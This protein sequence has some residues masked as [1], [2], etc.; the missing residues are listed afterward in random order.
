MLKWG[1]SYDTV[2]LSLVLAMVKND[3]KLKNILPKSDQMVQVTW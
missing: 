1:V 3:V 2:N